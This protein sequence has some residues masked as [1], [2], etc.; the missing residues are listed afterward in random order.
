MVSKPRCNFGWVVDIN[1]CHNYYFVVI[2]ICF[3]G[4]IEMLDGFKKFIAKGNVLDMAVGVLIGG[5]FGKIVSSLVADIIT[6][7]LSIFTNKIDLT[8]LFLV[9]GS[10]QAFATVDE[11]KAAGVTTLSYGVFL[12]NVLDFLIIAIVIYLFVSQLAKMKERKNPTVPAP[13]IEKK[14]CPYCLTEI[15]KEATRC[16]NCTSVLEEATD[17]LGTKVETES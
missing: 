10:N 11:A 17:V 3:F 13:V 15:R 9:I 8:N 16:P 12:Q 4:G 14:E 6:P 2:I 5:A 7:L 1:P